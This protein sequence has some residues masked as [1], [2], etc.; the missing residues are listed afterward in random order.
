[1][2]TYPA[3]GWMTSTVPVWDP[4]PLARVVVVVP[5]PD[6]LDTYE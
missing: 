6:V 3:L 5:A 1:M 2:V 4:V